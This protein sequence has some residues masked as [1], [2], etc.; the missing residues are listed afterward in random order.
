MPLRT[1]NFWVSEHQRLNVDGSIYIRY[2]APPYY[3]S[4]A[5]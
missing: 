3:I 1:N 4:P 2:A 5:L